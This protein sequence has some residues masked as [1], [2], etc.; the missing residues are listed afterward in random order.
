MPLSSEEGPGYLRERIKT[1][2]KWRKGYK[3]KVSLKTSP[4]PPNGSQSGMP[5]PTASVSPRNLLEMQILSPHRIPTESETLGVESIQWHCHRPC[6]GC[7][8][9]LKFE[10]H[11]SNV[12]HSPCITT[13]VYTITAGLNDLSD[14]KCIIFR[15]VHVGSRSHLR[16]R[17]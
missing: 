1:P 9:T 7:W 8:C 11:C 15:K 12:S 13:L 2:L 6:G 5:E 14:S 10:K 4:S 17:L 3:N 16:A